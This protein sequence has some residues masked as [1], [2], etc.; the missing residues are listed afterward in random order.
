MSGI[1]LYNDTLFWS[2]VLLAE[3][4]VVGGFLVVFLARMAKR[5]RVQHQA[6]DML[7]NIDTS[8]REW[9]AS[10]FLKHPDEI[11]IG[12]PLFLELCNELAHAGIGGVNQASLVQLLLERGSVLNEHISIVR[13]WVRYAAGVLGSVGKDESQ[14][15]KDL[16]YT[17]LIELRSAKA[18]EEQDEELL[19]S[20]AID[21]GED[22]DETISFLLGVFKRRCKNVALVARLNSY[23]A[24]I[25]FLRG[26]LASEAH[27]LLLEAYQLRRDAWAAIALGQEAYVAGDHQACVRLLGLAAAQFHDVDL[28]CI[29]VPRAKSLIALLEAAPGGSVAA[30]E[31]SEPL[32]GFDSKNLIEALE[33]GLKH[34]SQDRGLI[35]ALASLY[36]GLGSKDADAQQAYV[37]LLNLVRKPDEVPA[38]FMQTM[39]LALTCASEHSLPKGALADLPD[40]ARS[41][42]RRCLEESLQKAIK[43]GDL[44]SE[45]LFRAYIRSGGRT[46]EILDAAAATSLGKSAELQRALIDGVVAGGHFRFEQVSAMIE[47]LTADRRPSEAAE[48]ITRM[49][50][51]LETGKNQESGRERALLLL[52]AYYAGEDQQGEWS[53]RDYANVRRLSVQLRGRQTWT[54]NDRLQ[55][56]INAMRSHSGTAVTHRRAMLLA[57]LVDMGNLTTKTLVSARELLVDASQSELSTGST[58]FDALVAKL[59]EKNP[60]EIDVLVREGLLSFG[61]ESHRQISNGEISDVYLWAIGEYLKNHPG[62]VEL[63]ALFFDC[64]SLTEDRDRYEPLLQSLAEKDPDIREELEGMKL[65]GAD[66]LLDAGNHE[67]GILV[68]LGV[69]RESKSGDLRTEAFERILQTLRRVDD[70]HYITQQ[71]D[72]LEPLLEGAAQAKSL[73]NLC[74]VKKVFTLKAF[75]V[76][77]RW[78]ELSK[79]EDPEAIIDTKRIFLDDYLS[80]RD[81]QAVMDCIKSIEKTTT[82]LSVRNVSDRLGEIYAKAAR[83][84]PEDERVYLG[85]GDFLFNTGDPFGAFVQYQRLAKIRSGDEKLAERVWKVYESVHR[86]MA[87]GDG[88]PSIDSERGIKLLEVVSLASDLSS[89]SGTTDQ[90]QRTLDMLRDSLRMVDDAR[91]KIEIFGADRQ[92][93]GVIVAKTLSSSH[94][95]IE[96]RGREF[97]NKIRKICLYLLQQ[98]A[99]RT[100]LME[101]LANVDFEQ[102]IWQRAGEYYYRLILQQSSGRLAKPTL[103]EYYNRYFVCYVRLGTDWIEDALI[104][105]KRQ[106]M[107]EVKQLQLAELSPDLARA[108]GDFIESLAAGMH[109]LGLQA[110]TTAERRTD[111]LKDA[112]DLYNKLAEGGVTFNKEWRVRLR[113][114]TQ[115]LLESKQSTVFNPFSEI[116][117]FKPRGNLQVKSEELSSNPIGV[118]GKLGQRYELIEQITKQGGFGDLYLA[119]DLT[120]DRLVAVKMLKKRREHEDF[121]RDLFDFRHEANTMK[122]ASHPNIVDFFDAEITENDQYIVMEYVDGGDLLEHRNDQLAKVTIARALEIVLKVASA[123]GYMHHLGI[124]HR[125]I[126]PKNILIGK[127]PGKVKVTDFGLARALG[128]EG[129]IRSATLTGAENFLAPEIYKNRTWSVQS[130]IF[131]IGILLNFLLTDF[132]KVDVSL[133]DPEELQP[134]RDIIVKATANTN[135]RRYRTIPE[136]LSDFRMLV[137]DFY[138]SLVPTWEEACE[139]TE[140]VLDENGFRERFEIIEVLAQSDRAIVS[141]ALRHATGAEAGLPVAIKEIRTESEE[142]RPVIERIRRLGHFK[143]YEHPNIVRTMEWHRL[144]DRYCVVTE[145]IEGLSLRQLLDMRRKRGESFS[146]PEFSKFIRDVAQGLSFLHSRRI[147]HRN[148]KPSN[149][150]L[151]TQRRMAR[152]TNLALAA[153]VSESGNIR[154]DMLERQHIYCAPEVVAHKPYSHQADIYSLGV[155][156][157]EM[158]TGS[159]DDDINAQLVVALNPG[160]DREAIEELCKFVANCCCINPANRIASLEAVDCELDRLHTGRTA[161]DWEEIGSNESAETVRH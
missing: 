89:M 50:D 136:M 86:E 29:V 121:M 126:H 1:L 91:R 38:P 135:E 53:D 40:R 34:E 146:L 147:V 45:D 59:G 92:N 137:L 82:S 73:K 74:I 39:A 22:D 15:H 113:R 116:P 134:F 100:D 51:R 35:M 79:G 88:A 7:F 151:D 98:S 154:S 21:R 114:E 120:N 37:R 85:Y 149:I 125:D 80:R 138:P 97:Q 75:D 66:R 87:G 42:I 110:D 67:R 131:S 158:L 12:S 11:P 70:P 104:F 122:N 142:N 47:K 6:T 55:A 115:R 71:V 72:V 78:E 9:I 61:R 157:K 143:W 150:L 36:A 161:I 107:S 160:T 128:T 77:T 129:V 153:L 54:L 119:R 49:L 95:Q 41:T 93:Q 30:C 109:Y 132:Q 3:S 31:R 84:F 148:L 141:R 33:S 14:R 23:L 62:D 127:D 156:M 57:S 139:R 43:G 140:P 68:L 102:G 103:L 60:A 17:L 27:A 63:K 76:V 8:D 81:R 96:E 32:P 19:V 111:H 2:A 152:V 159:A 58:L 5:R 94:L 83:A 20:L 101:L 112:L 64:F 18:L 90:M 4:A 118:W 69:M 123:V 65:A 13:A 133:L 145:F 46:V 105:S 108:Y 124:I 25:A 28:R 155:I 130:D 48:L 56:R 16:I 52:L 44:P 10:F 99:E 144:R 117:R 106:L 24:D 26:G